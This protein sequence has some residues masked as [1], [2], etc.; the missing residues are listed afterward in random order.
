MFLLPVG[1][2]TFPHQ[3]GEIKAEDNKKKSVDL[4]MSHSLAPKKNYFYRLQILE[5]FSVHAK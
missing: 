1:R 5:L 2:W 3:N 4:F